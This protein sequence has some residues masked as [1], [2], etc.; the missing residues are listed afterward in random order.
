MSVYPRNLSAFLNR[1]S[2]YNKSNVKVN[3]L[4]A[5]AAK[6]GDT[7]QIDLPTNSIVDLSS[8]A[9]A[10]KIV[11]ADPTAGGKNIVPPINAEALI[12]RLAVEVNGQTLS[13]IQN[14]NVLFHMLL[15]MSATE[16]YQRQRCLNQSNMAADATNGQ[17]V[18]IAAAADATA[19]TRHHVIDSWLGFLGTAKPSFID[20]SLLGNVRITI[21]LAGPE[22]INGDDAAVLR[23]YEIS[24]Q[25]WT[26]DVISISDGI[27][28]SMIDQRLAS[29][30][31]IEMP[32]KN[33]FSFTNS[34]GTN[35]AQQ[36]NFNVASQSIDRLWA[37]ARAATHSGATQD[38]AAVTA[39]NHSLV[40]AD[41]PAFR[42]AQQG[43]SHWQFQINNTLYPNFQPVHP[44]VLFSQTK[45]AL[46]D[47]GNMLSGC[48]PQSITHYRD[49]FFVFA[50]SL[51]H[52][53]GDDER[54]MSGIDT[55]GAAASCHLKV[56]AGGAES[57]TAADN[58]T[59]VF[60]ECTSSLKIHA[61]K[62]L[63][64]VQ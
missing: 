63:E 29:G 35:M 46:G 3:V 64:V 32:F 34:N 27:Y 61:N 7:I 57:G 62:V 53:T 9:W 11:Y 25:F 56:E 50:Q 4:G 23:A 59:L 42:F 40:V 49:H 5:T 39:P 60:A 20:T 38:K 47:M 28:D 14:Y 48:V 36:L 26:M 33:Y 45:N 41:Q 8:L 18:H 22:V 55:R 54:Y 16:D 2:G 6:Q 31:P 19:R 58:Q 24:E 12:N 15:Y 10:F 13:N 44:S 43:G 30:A 17:A 37:T 52:K 21:T 1:L 51:E